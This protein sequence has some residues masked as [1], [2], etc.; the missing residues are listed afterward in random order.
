MPKIL[1]FDTE[2]TGL[3]QITDA[4]IPE[5]VNIPKDKNWWNNLF[6]TRDN[7]YKNLHNNTSTS[8]PEWTKDNNGKRIVDK[9]SHI[10][11]LSYIFYDTSDPGNP[12]IFDKYIE[13]GPE[14]EI[15]SKSIAVHH[16]DREKIDAEKLKG[17]HLPLRMPSKNFYQT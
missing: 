12:K 14:V 15:D 13:I 10:L 3:P 16:I 1:V 6:E 7:F 5:I 4:D 17:K 11:Q 2:T 8:L 9:W